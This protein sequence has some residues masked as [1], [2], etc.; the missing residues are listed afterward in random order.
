MLTAA[1]VSD[2]VG[3]PVATAPAQGLCERAV[4]VEDDAVAEA[5]DVLAPFGAPGVSPA[6]P[7]ERYA[8]AV[9]RLA[10]AILAPTMG[11]VRPTT[12]GGFTTAVGPVDAREELISV[13]G[14]KAL[15][16]SLR[17]Q[18]HRDLGI[19]RRAA[20]AADTDA[21][22]PPRPLALYVV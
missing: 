22:P 8:R 13:N 6:E 16:A 19:L 7:R 10:V 14:A 12:R 17:E 9:A 20:Q 1:L 15:A 21:T 5:L 18:A 4:L 2:A 11:A 3:L